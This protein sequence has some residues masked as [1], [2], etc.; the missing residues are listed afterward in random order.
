MPSMSHPAQHGHDGRPTEEIILGVDTHK[1]AHVA[2]VI[3]ILGVPVATATF[4]T[5]TAGYR[6]LLAWARSFGVLC[7][8]GIGRPP[9][10]APHSSRNLP[11]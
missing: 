1:D 10:T 6:E 4:P 7:R 11:A 5:T 3:T 9:S 2:A 8:A